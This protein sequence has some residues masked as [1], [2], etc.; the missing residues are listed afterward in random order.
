[1]T[2]GDDSAWLDSGGSKKNP[3]LRS[4]WISL[5]C[6]TAS[7][8]PLISR[9]N[10]EAHRPRAHASSMSCTSAAARSVA[11]RQGRAPNCWGWRTL[12]LMATHASRWA[13]RR[14]RPFPKVERRY[15]SVCYAAH[16]GCLKY[17]A[18][19]VLVNPIPI[20]FLGSFAAFYNLA[21]RHLS[22]LALA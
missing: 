4:R 7:N 6:R 20:H 13:I 16:V 8:A 3:W 1:V 12:C 21:R 10:I 17:V 2:I 19:G 15:K 14:S 22:H 11:E 18:P 5:P 9:V